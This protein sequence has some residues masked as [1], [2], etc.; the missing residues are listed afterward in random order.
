MPS[1]NLELKNKWPEPASSHGRKNGYLLL[2][3]GRLKKKDDLLSS[4]A[5][6][7]SFSI[8]AIFLPITSTT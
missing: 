7:D 5:P 2:P 3:C 8:L 1:A 4:L 6:A